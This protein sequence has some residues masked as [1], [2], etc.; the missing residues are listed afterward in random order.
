M[1]ERIL[2]IPPERMKAGREHRV[3]LSDAA[4]NVLNRMAEVRTGDLVFPGR[5]G[6]S[7][8]NDAGLFHMLRRM[9][10]KDLTTHGFRST[11]ATW[12]A[13]RTSYPFEVR[14]LALA[15][16]VGDAVVRAYQRSDLFDRRRRLMDDWSR[17]C[18]TPAAES[19][20]VVAIGA[21]G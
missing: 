6:V 15:H 2:T 13:D 21:A 9:G 10:R 17:F 19:A 14:E 5:D 12:A 4:V 18:S 20:N 16:A 1:A 7:K 11:F 3:P 8:I